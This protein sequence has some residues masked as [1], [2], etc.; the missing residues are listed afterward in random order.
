MQVPL[1][2]TFRNM[3]RD[4]HVAR[5]INSQVMKWEHLKW[6]RQLPMAHEDR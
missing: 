1:D 5:W 4:E 6:E 2:V 3:D